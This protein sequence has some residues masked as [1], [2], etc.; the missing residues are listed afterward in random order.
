MVFDGT[1]EFTLEPGES[2]LLPVRRAVIADSAWTG[3]E[4]IVVIQG[5]PL[6]VV[7]GIWQTGQEVGS[8]LVINDSCTDQ[9]IAL[10]DAVGAVVPVALQTRE[11]PQCGCFDTDAWVLESGDSCQKCGRPTAGGPSACRACGSA[12]VNV[13]HYS[14]CQDCAPSVF[15]PVSATARSASMS[16]RMTQGKTV[17]SATL[18]AES[19]VAS[20]SVRHA[21]YHIVEELG[22]V[23]WMTEV[24]TPPEEYYVLLKRSLTSPLS[25]DLVSDVVR[26]KL[27][28]QKE[29]C[30]AITFPV[31]VQNQ[32][33]KEFKQSWIL[34]ISKN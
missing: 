21:V 10:G 19:L 28:C 9:H 15:G 27:W 12:E 5:H 4:A 13:L 30:W 34:L 25:V 26:H 24:E 16:V 11:C 23:D 31:K 3:N 7:P 2:V 14:G 32:T 8:V 17:C 22:G 6:Q 1:E 20:H 18:A 33:R 29:N